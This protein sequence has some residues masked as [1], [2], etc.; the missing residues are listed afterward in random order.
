MTWRPLDLICRGVLLRRD[1]DPDRKH[2][3]VDLALTFVVY[4]GAN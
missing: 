3:R 4:E 2:V 1:R